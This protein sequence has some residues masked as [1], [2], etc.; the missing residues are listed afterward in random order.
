MDAKLQIE[1]AKGKCKDTEEKNRKCNSLLV[2]IS[3]IV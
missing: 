3:K 2:G 1:K